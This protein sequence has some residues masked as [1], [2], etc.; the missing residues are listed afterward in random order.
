MKTEIKVVTP[1]MAAVYLE[2]NTGNRKAKLSAIV[3]YSG[4]L[5]RGEWILTHQGIAISS[6]GNLLDG[7]QRLMAIVKTGISAEMM[8]TTGVP[9]DAFIAM[10]QGAIRS[11][12]DVTKL[13]RRVAEV[14]TTAFRLSQASEKKPT[15]QAA[16]AINE[17]IGSR[18]TELI[19][20][21]GTTSAVF[22]SAP[23]KL[24][25]VV[26][27]FGK[28]DNG[29][30]FDVYRKLVN[31]DLDDLPILANKLVKQKLK[32]I[33]KT[34]GS[35]VSRHLFYLAMITFDVKNK[36]QTLSCTESDNKISLDKLKQLIK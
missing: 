12:A 18:I 8:I 33:I 19:Y 29:Y 2:C 30:A 4:I 22:S 15:G 36:R 23:F 24:A 31:L 16:L 25:A 13:D 28:D 27:S 21:C 34:G 14:I 9:D 5:E 32:G 17:K 3:T 1:D 10:D 11:M 35:S 7:Q 20:H 26:Q 6:T